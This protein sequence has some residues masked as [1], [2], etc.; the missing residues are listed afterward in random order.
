MD[1]SASTHLGLRD[2]WLTAGLL[3]IGLVTFAISA[4]MTNLILPKLMTSMRVELYHIHWVV[5]AFSIARTITIPA[6]GWMSGRVGPRALYLISLGGFTFGMLGA[7]LAWDWTSLLFFR[8]ITGACGGLIPPLSM[9]IFYQIFPPNQ[10]G[11][12]LGLSLMGWSIGPA[13]GPLTGGYLLEFASWRVAYVIIVPLS[14][15]GLMA[16]W[17]LLPPLK[18][19]ERRALDVYGLL[20][21]AIAV[22]TY[23]IALSQGR[24]EGWE[25]QGII[26]LLAV[27]AVSAVVFIVIEL[28]RPQPLVELR[29]LASPPFL[30]AVVVMYL[31]TMTF[32]STG[33]MMPVLMQRL[34]GFEPLLVAWTMLPSQII[35]GLVVLATGRLSDRVSP[36]VLVVSGLVIYAG[37]FIG[38]S[39]LTIWTTSLTVSLFLVVRFT[40]E[41]LIVSPNNLTAMRA[42]PEHQV[43]M[44]AGLIG[45]MRSV[46]NTLGPAVASVLWDQDYSRHIQHIAER[47]PADSFAFVA[48]LKQFQ[49]SLVWLGEGAFQ[50]P[51]KSLAL[52]GRLLHTEAST[53][54]WQSYF[55]WNGALGLIAIIPSLLVANRLWRRARTPVPEA[56]TETVEPTTALSRPAAR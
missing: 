43:M 9:A 24:R 1:D 49:D 33:P 56:E 16:A 46:A 21:I 11:M 37:A 42:L 18:R 32:R 29:L 35:Y 34:L 4:S 25:S 41:G 31:T 12:A 39:N 44:A 8:I 3:G 55:L 53:A 48:A 45:L 14:G 52:M 6:L 51:V 17:L 26:V 47:S 20:S 27:S 38:F 23:L 36:T 22:T 7:S 13:I 28:R 50:V 30:M 10:R 5:T 40:A 2:R 15:I 54:A 19:P